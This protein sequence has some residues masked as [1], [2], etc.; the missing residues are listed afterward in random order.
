MLAP[1]VVESIPFDNTSQRRTFVG[2]STRYGGGKETGMAVLTEIYREPINQMVTSYDITVQLKS[3]EFYAAMGHVRM[4]SVSEVG[5]HL[6]RI[7][8]EKLPAG[9]KAPKVDSLFVP[10]ERFP[11]A[12]WSE[13]SNVQ[14]RAVAIEV[15]KGGNPNSAKFVFIRMQRGNKKVERKRLTATAKEGDIVFFCDYAHEIRAIVPMN[16]K[17]KVTGW[18]ELG[19]RHYTEAELI[20]NKT[21]FVRPTEV[22]DDAAWK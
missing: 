8:K 22:K 9:A 10:F 12:G 7:P 14:I 21:P 3:G 19:P 18:V 1:K 20:A 4:A 6:H 17:T 15:G 16:E 13:I 5:A 11:F 2:F